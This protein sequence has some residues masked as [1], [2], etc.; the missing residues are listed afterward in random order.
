M[1]LVSLIKR[2]SSFRLF[3]YP[4]SCLTVLLAVAVAGLPVPDLHAQSQPSSQ[5]A[6]TQQGQSGQSGQAKPSSSQQQNQQN[7]TP[8]AGGPQGDIG[9]IAVPKKGEPAPKKD[10][11]PK[12]P[13]TP[14]NMPNFSMHVNVP[15]VTLDVGVLATKNQMFI[16]GLKEQFFKVYEDGV[17]QKISTFNQT[18]APITAVVLVEYANTFYPFQTDALLASYTFASMLGKSDWVA[19]VSYDMRPHI[20]TDFTQN[21]QEVMAG[22]STLQTPGF[23]ETNLFDALY[24]TIDRL[25]GVE[26]RK[27]I[28]L[29]SS[30]RDTFSKH[31][32]DQMLKKIKSTKDVVIYSVGTGQAL[33]NYAESNGLMRYLC[34]ITTFDCRTE[35]NQADNQLTS[36]ARMTGGRAYFPIFQ[37][38]FREIFA[39]IG[40]TIRN[41]YT[42]TYHPTNSAQ[43]GSYRK[44]KVELLGSEGKPLKIT[45]E[46]GKEVKYEIISREGY[47]AKRQVE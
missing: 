19:L 11:T 4:A 16:P 32:L 45:D 15:L 13:E 30:G 12:P 24:D 40:Q 47:T 38:Q 2:S 39:D 28:I 23:S 9:P 20:L 18:Q 17:E 35:F 36:F 6:Q 42:I 29:V 33:R 1:V 22:V 44:I 8:E 21:K 14:K 5:P 43:D 26:G 27:Y 31:T 10:D 34:D 46:K 37:A 41:Q 25:E 3:T 7:S